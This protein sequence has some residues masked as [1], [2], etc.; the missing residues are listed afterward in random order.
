MNFELFVYISYIYNIFIRNIHNLFF[1]FLF[2]KI[3]VPM[4][5][6]GCVRGTCIEPNV[7]RCDFGYVGANCSI[8]CQCNGHSNCAGPDRLDVCLECH[9]NT[10]G[11]QCDKCLPLFVGNPADNGQC[12]PCL[13]YCNGHTRICI[14]ESMTVP[15]I[16]SSY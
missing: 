15:V 6:Q 9:N 7:C 3:C 10:M 1:F 11:P 13:E 2:R 5:T 14:N 8:Q 12:V 16:Y 4:C